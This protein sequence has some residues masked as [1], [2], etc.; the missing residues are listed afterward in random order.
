[1]EAEKS[2]TS[3]EQWYEHVTNLDRHWKKSRREEERLKGKNKQVSVPRNQV[4]RPQI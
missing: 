3:I 2:P 1:M 4:S